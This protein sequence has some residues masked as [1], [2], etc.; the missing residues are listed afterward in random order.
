M[1]IEQIGSQFTVEK[2]KELAKD[3]DICILYN[4]YD[5]LKRQSLKLGKN[6]NYIGDF[7]HS[8]RLRPLSV[9]IDKKQDDYELSKFAYSLESNPLSYIVRISIG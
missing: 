7:A 9:A 2:L 4:C 1:K 5:F 3:P 6:E 8:W